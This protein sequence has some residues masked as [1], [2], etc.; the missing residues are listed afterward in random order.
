MLFFV[1]SVLGAISL[2]LLA[3]INGMPIKRWAFLGGVLG[4][5]ALV[6]YSMHLRR[7]WMKTY[8][9]LPYIKWRA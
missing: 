9:L 2:F 1:F 8:R 5:F 6:L 7:A 3:T 4:P